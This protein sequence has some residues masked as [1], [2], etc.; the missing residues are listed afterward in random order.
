MFHI[1][2]DVE[3]C[4]SVYP[5]LLGLFDL[6]SQLVIMYNILDLYG[7]DNSW[8]ICKSWTPF[9]GV[10]SYLMAECWLQLSSQEVR[11]HTC[12]SHWD[13]NVLGHLFM[14]HVHIRNGSGTYPSDT[15]WERAERF[16]YIKCRGRS[17]IFENQDL[18]CASGKTCSG[19]MHTHTHTHKCFQTHS[20]PLI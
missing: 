15:C 12:F 13:M 3:A 20:W 18:S 16:T 19:E 17:D 8:G 6:G 10:D 2:D 1:H 5:L 4:S 7:Y 11:V 14:Y 9:H